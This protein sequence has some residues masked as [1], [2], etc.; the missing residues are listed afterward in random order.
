MA[1][2]AERAVSPGNGAVPVRQ[3]EPAGRRRPRRH[4]RA[5]GDLL[6]LAPRPGIVDGSFHQT[7]AVRHKEILALIDAGVTV[8]GA[9]SMGALRAAELDTYGMIGVGR[10]Y[11][12][13]RRAG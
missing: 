4:R 9:A 6:R 13:F 1:G 11:D 5:A 2:I 10:V 12:D 7:R 8:L 3:P